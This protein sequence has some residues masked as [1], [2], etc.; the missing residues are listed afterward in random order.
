MPGENVTYNIFLVRKMLS[1]GE[2]ERMVTEGPPLK[3]EHDRVGA[4]NF[5]LVLPAKLSP[6]SSS[7]GQQPYKC[8]ECGKGFG[9]SSHLMRHLGTYSGEKPYSVQTAP[10]PSHSCQACGSTSECTQRSVPVS[11]ISAANASGIPT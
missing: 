6:V 8:M 3:L 1:R 5:T 2:P 11:V 10:R 4:G 7:E 9:Q